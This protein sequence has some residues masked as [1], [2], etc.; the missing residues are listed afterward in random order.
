L[1]AA[2]KLD[3]LA[4][5]LRELLSSE[6]GLPAGV[7]LDRKASYEQGKEDRIR[8]ITQS[9]SSF[10]LNP[11]AHHLGTR[12]VVIVADGSLRGVPFGIL[13]LSST[14]TL[15]QRNGVTYLPSI[16]ALRWLRKADYQA[17]TGKSLAIFADPVFDLH[18]S[19]LTAKT[20]DAHRENTAVI[21]AL[22]D[23]SS[24]SLTRLAWSR[25]EAQ[26]IARD[27][28]GKRA[29]V[30]VDFDANRSAA[31]HASWQDYSI[32]HFATHALIDSRNPELSGIVLSLYDSNGRPV[33]GFLR[34]TDI[35]NLAIPAQLVVLST[36]D[37]AA[38]S[39]AMGNDI[40]TLSD[41]FFYA[42]APRILATLWSVN[43][44]AAA[45]FMAHFYRA[46]L[47]RHMPPSAALQS[48]KAAMARDP[49]WKLPYYWS[50]FV[51]EG[52]WR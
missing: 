28:P 40:Y 36:C 46:L 24:G 5:R 23:A 37:S 11:V 1:P 8:T 26:I 32:A 42:G 52:D 10:L 34:V 13:P 51:L 49:R 38:D 31:I 22:H 30:A 50:G 25:R 18:D 7:P 2:R 33:D 29:W 27:L 12:N 4:V 15:E 44:E 9:L 21:R 41:A 20:E 45:V 14:R 16:G 39:A 48:A 6:Q 17:A 47:A 35:Y 43:D 3:S 19:R